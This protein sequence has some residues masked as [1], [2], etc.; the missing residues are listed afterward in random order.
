MQPVLMSKTTKLHPVTIIMGLLIFGH[1][2]G[3]IGMVVSTPLIAII[4]II[5]TFFD[6]K[7]DF[8]KN[9]D[10]SVE[11]LE[12]TSKKVIKKINDRKIEENI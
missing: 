8:F 1:Y 5:Y 12:E 3:M 6:E 4:K 10:K 9:N 7:Y 2:W 11:E